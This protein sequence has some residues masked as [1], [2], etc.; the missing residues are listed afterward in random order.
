[1]SPAMQT[2]SVVWPG[3]LQA[4]RAHY[5]AVALYYSLSTHIKGTNKI[6][7]EVHRQI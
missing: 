4:A 7:G 3:R 2:M 5:T 6:K 1:M